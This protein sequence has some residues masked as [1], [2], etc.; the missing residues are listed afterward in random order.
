[1][2]A[3][4]YFDNNAT[5]LLAPEVFE[6]MSQELNAPPSNPSSVHEYGRGARSRLAKA[7]S[8]IA[9]YLK[10]KPSEIIFTSGGTE[11]M[12]GLI[13]GYCE[14]LKPGHIITSSIEHSCV[15]KTLAKLEEKGWKVSYLP[16]SIEG[17]VSPE[18][19]DSA[20][21]ANTHL[22][23]LSAANSET[24]VKHDIEKIAQIAEKQKIGF[25]VD[26]VAL[27][28]KS[29]LTIPKG[30]T[31]M[32]FSAH[33]FHGPKGIGFCYV[34]S[35]TKIKPIIFGGEQEFTLRSGT[36][37]LPG[38]MGLAKAIEMIYESPPFDEMETHRIYFEN[39]L[40]KNA[41]PLFINGEG[42]K[43]S[44]VSNI[45]FPGID[46]ETLLIQLDMHGVLASQGSACASGSLEPSKVLL[47]MG[48]GTDRAKNSLRFSF[49]RYTTKEDI[50]RA[51]KIVIALI[52][53]M[54][55]F[56]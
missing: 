18:Q 48:L 24:G 17:C 41:S 14:P 4:I 25:I 6:A 53:Q 5:T 29:P 36:E 35:P 2:H 40:I 26:A 27:L 39:Q 3:K 13:Q 49:S 10:A 9:S 55:E 38:I 19:V 54:R 20:I 37:N 8:S 47:G 33:K 46:G 45:Y 28:G 42:E 44:N 32:G 16:A 52:G 34:K 22:I 30:V 51:L 1:M 7:R 43:V 31:A 23:V 21:E 15:Q 56:S 50:D 12:N 11:S